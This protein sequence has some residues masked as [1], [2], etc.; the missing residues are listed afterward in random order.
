MEFRR[1]LFRSALTE[2]LTCPW[3]VDTDVNGA[4]LAEYRWGAGKDCSSLCYFTIGTGLG[5]GLLIDGRPVHG[6]MHPAIGHL[7]I[8]RVP[9]DTF[10]GTCPFHGDCIEV[11]VSGPARADRSGIT[12]APVN[13]TPPRWQKRERT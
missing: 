4:A 13:E 1:V 12:P 9:G 10:A 2:G 7:R 3:A 5:G 8:R 6:A 11:L